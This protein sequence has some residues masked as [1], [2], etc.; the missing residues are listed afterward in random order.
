MTKPDEIMAEHLLKGGK[1]LAKTCNNCGN[2]LFE[3]K[4]ETT[5][6]VCQT[7]PSSGN[8]NAKPPVPGSTTR[9]KGADP[10]QGGRKGTLAPVIEAAV[11][12]LCDRASTDPNPANC[13]L[14]M[15]AAECGVRALH[16]LQE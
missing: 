3:V 13:L 9:K 11:A 6:V 5:C 12:A 2:P 15:Q 14:L 8:D 1:M 16:E 7:P 4:G 10:V